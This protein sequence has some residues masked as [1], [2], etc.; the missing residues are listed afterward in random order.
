LKFRIDLIYELL[1]YFRYSMQHKFLGHQDYN[2]L[3]RPAEQHFP[4]R[5]PP[6]ENKCKWKKF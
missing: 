1:E 6:T 5:I 4:W 3:K 2:T